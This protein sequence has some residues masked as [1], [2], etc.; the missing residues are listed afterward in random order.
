VAGVVI[1]TG[2]GGRLDVRVGPDGAYSV[3]LPAG[4]YAVVG[5]SP[6]VTIE[7]VAMPCP[8][9]REVHVTSGAVVVLD[10]ICTIK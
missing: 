3:G 1:V 8:G 10:A 5:H 6:S 9:T 4:Q 2:A 7:G